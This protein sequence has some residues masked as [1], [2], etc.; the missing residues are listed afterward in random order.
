MS[1]S[2]AAL[3]RQV[4]GRELAAAPAELDLRLQDL[5]ELRQPTAERGVGLD[6]ARVRER[7]DRELRVEQLQ[8]PEQR[9]VRDQCACSPGARP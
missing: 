5:P 9:E 4:R 2:A 7:A 6:A 3:P 1:A 8:Q